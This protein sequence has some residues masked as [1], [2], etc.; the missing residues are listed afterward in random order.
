MNVSGN[1]PDD[2]KHQPQCIMIKNYFKVAIRN[3]IKQKIYAVINILGLTIGI[4]CCLLILLY[5]QDELSYDR[6]HEHANRIYRVAGDINFGGHHWELAVAPTPMAQALVNDFPEVVSAV[7]FREQGS[8]LVRRGQEDN[9]KETRVIFADS[10]LFQVFTIPLLQGDA[11]SALKEPNTLVISESTA[12]K[13][14]ADEMQAGES[15]LDQTITL[16]NDTDYKIT[17]VY[18]DIPSNSHFHFDLILSMEGLEESKDGIWLSNNFNTY[19]LLAEGAEASDLEAKFPG[20]VDKYVLPQAQQFLQQEFDNAQEVIHYYL[21]PLTDIHLHSDLTAELEGNSSILYVYI[22]SAIAILIL[23]I[24]CIN[25][26]NLSTARSATRAKEVG[27]RKV[28]GS[29]RSSL[30]AQFLTESILISLISFTLAIFLVDLVL[31]FYNNFTGKE[32]TLPL[33]DP[34]WVI[35]ALLAC[36]CIVGIAAG[37]YPAFFLSAFQPVNVLKG[38]F[39]ASSQGVLLRKGLV[40]FQFSISIFLVAGTLIIYEQLNYIQQKK[41]GFNKEQVIIVEDAYA[42]GNQLE[43]FKNEMGQNTA[44]QYATISSFLPVPSAR[45]DFPLFPEGQYNPESAVSL[46]NWS[47][48][49]DYVRTMGMEIIAGR[50]FSRDFSTDSSGIILNEAAVKVFGFDEPIGK[51]LTEYDIQGNPERSFEV[52]GVV[53]DF[54]FESLR[55]HI[56]ALALRLGNSRGRIAFR[57]QTENVPEVIAALEEKWKALAP[58]QPF[59]YSFLDERFEDT[60]RAEQKMGNIFTAFAFLAIFTACLGLFGLAAYTA[61]QRTKE[62]GIRKVLGA[63]V[64]DVVALLSKDFTLLVIMAILV[65][66]PVTYLAMRLWLQDFAYRIDIGWGTFIIAGVAALL[67]AWLTVSYQSIKAAL[68]NPVNSLRNE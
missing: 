33:F 61:S 16:D 48:D 21:Q 31:P 51:K 37:S 43:S 63:S 59:S 12:H 4:A 57:L 18:E 2:I 62:I 34:I 64:T 32:L 49:H 30:M 9:I 29:L 42:L 13:Y 1:H 45:T 11:S 35:P 52:I 53:K 68:A 14:F 24:A 23:L 22:F 60:Y 58:D 54:H 27:I 44:I 3:L 56:S 47:V 39:S 65:A 26:M 50:D 28:V 46:Q 67:I 25:F 17:G 10:S 41:L 6:Y 19:I 8:F 36:A 15:I 20:M 66:T 5:V 38:K 55:Q 40:V 7:R